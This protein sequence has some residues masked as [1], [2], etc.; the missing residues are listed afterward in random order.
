MTTTLQDARVATA[1]ERMFTRANEQ[2][3]ELRERKD[4]FAR[5]SSATAQE[6]AD[7]LSDPS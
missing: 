1:L 7:A 6:R 3:L 4:E 2:L 5:L